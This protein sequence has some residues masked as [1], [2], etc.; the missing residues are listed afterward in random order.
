M[1]ED[2]LLNIGFT[3]KDGNNNG[4]FYYQNDCFYIELSFDGKYFFICTNMSGDREG[5]PH[6][7]TTI[8]KLLILINAY[9]EFFK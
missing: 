2:D 4:W 9:K 8:E 7:L 5:A 3:I 1:T 6:P